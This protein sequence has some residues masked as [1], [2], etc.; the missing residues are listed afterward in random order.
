MPNSSTT[1]A[2]LFRNYYA[3]ISKRFCDYICYPPE[4]K[5][6][7]V[8]LPLTKFIIFIAGCGLLSGLKRPHC[9]LR[10]TTILAL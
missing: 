8:M 9:L 4:K 10:L 5:Y 1:P 7:K 3:M 2:Q 6:V